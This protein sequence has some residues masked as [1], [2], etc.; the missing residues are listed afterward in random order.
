MAMHLPVKEKDVGSSPTLG[1]NFP[2]SHVRE[3]YPLD[4]DN[5]IMI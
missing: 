4:N 3:S 1:A 2:V 5:R